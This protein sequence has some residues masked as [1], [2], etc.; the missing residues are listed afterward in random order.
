MPD[1]SL[2]APQPPLV[3]GLPGHVARLGLRTRFGRA[4]MAGITVRGSYGS[5]RGVGGIGEW[6]VHALSL[7]LV[8]TVR[9]MFAVLVV[10]LVLMGSV[11]LVAAFMTDVVACGVV[12]I[13]A[14]SAT[15]VPSWRRLS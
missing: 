15:S 7:A 10:L 11:A 1:L 4:D 14:G 12:G 2:D 6:G 3:V 8:P 5:R 13:L 9:G